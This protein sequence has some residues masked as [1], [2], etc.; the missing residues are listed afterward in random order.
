LCSSLRSLQ[1]EDGS[2]L[3][4]AGK[5][6]LKAYDGWGSLRRE[7]R[8]PVGE[9]AANIRTA[10]LDGGCKKLFCDIQYHWDRL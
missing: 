8:L 6:H 4:E 7:E 10:A 9:A 2:I 1:F 5:R 3:Q